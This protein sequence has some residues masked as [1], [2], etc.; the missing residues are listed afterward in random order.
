MF[1]KRNIIVRV[2]Y[3]DSDII[4]TMYSLFLNNR[5]DFEWTLKK[6]KNGENG[7]EIVKE[8]AEW[9]WDDD[10]KRM[11]T[12][13]YDLIKWLDRNVN[14]DKFHVIDVNVNDPHD[15]RVYGRFGNPRLEVV[16]DL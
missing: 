9:S 10:P 6:F 16:S 14:P 1:G 15:L 12:T 8:N 13:I 11:Q 3:E 5:P 4:H 7:I 2:K